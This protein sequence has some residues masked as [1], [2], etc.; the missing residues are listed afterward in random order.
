MLWD[1]NINIKLDFG[2]HM[3]DEEQNGKREKICKNIIA[4]VKDQNSN[5]NN[6]NDGIDF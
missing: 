4:E 1:N 2:K 3:L 5:Q 6:I